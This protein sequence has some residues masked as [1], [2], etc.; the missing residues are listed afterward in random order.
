VS[1]ANAVEDVFNTLQGHA[2]ARSV[3]LSCDLPPELPSAY[4]DPTRLRQ[5]L[6]ILLDNAIKFTPN[7]GAAGIQARLDPDPRFL[8][9]DVSD[10]G[11]GISPER[12]ERIFER[13]Y[14]ESEPTQA[15]RKGLGLGLYICSELVTRQGGHIWVT[16][17]PQKGSTFSFTLPVFSPHNA[18]APLDEPVHV[19]RDSRGQPA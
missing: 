9:L 15:S 10:T 5:A 6:I 3:V 1:V 7:G 12:T 4:A 11:C 19:S 8:R 2:R 16:S 18:I 13:L 17:E 14:Q